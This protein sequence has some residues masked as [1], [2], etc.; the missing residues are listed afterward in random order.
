[1]VCMVVLMAAGLAGLSWERCC[2][3]EVQGTY[4]KKYK[5]CV[6]CDFYKKVKEEEYSKPQVE[7]EV[8]A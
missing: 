2:H 3:G 5:S 7:Q 4:A 8:S 1:M 6:Y